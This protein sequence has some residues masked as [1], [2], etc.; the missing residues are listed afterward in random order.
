V[1]Q[2]QLH[3]FDPSAWEDD[4]ERSRDCLEVL[5]F[6][7]S[8]D[9]VAAQFHEKLT[10]IFRQVVAYAASQNAT[11]S[12][13]TCTPMDQDGDPEP[14][15]YSYLLDIP[16]DSGSSHM[17]LS[18]VLLM[19]LSQPFGD[20]GARA[21]AEPNLQKHWLTD[22]S[23]YEYPQMAER[24]DWNLENRYMFHWDLSRLNIPSLDTLKT[25]GRSSSS[26][27]SSDFGMSDTM[28]PATFLGSTEP[29]GWTSAASLANVIRN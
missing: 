11:R 6:C 10:A 17:K 27:T 8:Q 13:E 5:A 4:L 14:V 23:R 18:F 2:K 15:D 16:A 28:S 26:E 21:E 20:P 9:R 1:V 12:S 29:S 22:P 3:N 25:S 7:G 24:V 19:M